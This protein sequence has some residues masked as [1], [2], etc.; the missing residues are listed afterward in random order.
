MSD[1]AQR[2]P[3]PGRRPNKQASSRARALLGEVLGNKDLF[4]AKIMP[5]LTATMVLLLQ[6]VSKERRETIKSV[7]PLL[8]GQNLPNTIS[9][10]YVRCKLR[11]DWQQADALYA[12][13]IWTEP[14][15]RG[16]QWHTTRPELVDAMVK[17]W[18][19][20][21]VS[22]ILAVHRPDQAMSFGK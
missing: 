12:V 8:Q 20:R 22:L 1:K 13:K 5:H 15:R 6:C 3:R 4:E 9:Q 21:V 11:F 10:Y 18:G 16:T 14:Y 19:W 17:L 7:L 2:A